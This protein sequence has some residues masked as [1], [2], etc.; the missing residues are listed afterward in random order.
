MEGRLAAISEGGLL[1][2]VDSPDGCGRSTCWAG[3][4]QGQSGDKA[5]GECEI[6]TNGTN[7]D[8]I[9]SVWRAVMGWSEGWHTP[10]FDTCGGP[11]VPN[12]AVVGW[13]C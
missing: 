2:S 11:G 6:L 10:W 12:P 4:S 5:F 3:E 9:K 7:Y 13:M 8:W 1:F